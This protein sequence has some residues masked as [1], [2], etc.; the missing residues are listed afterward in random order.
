[1]ATDDII[2]MTSS[3]GDGGNGEDSGENSGENSGEDS[4][5]NFER[6]MASSDGVIADDI[7][8]LVA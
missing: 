5:K 4:G 2:G 7:T 3:D 1:M 8:V 6:W